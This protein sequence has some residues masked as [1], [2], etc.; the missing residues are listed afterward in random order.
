MHTEQNILQ[1][2][3]NGCHG[4]VVKVVGR[5]EPSFSAAAPLASRQLPDTQHTLETDAHDT[6]TLFAFRYDCTTLNNN[7]YCAH[8]IHDSFFVLRITSPRTPGGTHRSDQQLDSR[9]H[10]THGKMG[11]YISKF[12]ALIWSK[13]EIRILILGLV[14]THHSV[15]TSSP[16]YKCLGQCRKD[17][18]AIQAEG[19]RNLFAG[20]DFF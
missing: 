2:G 20:P 13:K 3:P 1:M 11:G 7:S 5:S 18:V 4:P 14:C 17:D 9:I 12:S 6:R 16:D 10:R 8:S 15:R 19:G